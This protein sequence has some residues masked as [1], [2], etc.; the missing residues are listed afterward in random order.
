MKKF[1]KILYRIWKSLISILGYLVAL[2][3]IAVLCIVF[4]WYPIKVSSY[5][6][7]NPTH[8]NHKTSYLEDISSQHISDSLKPNVVI[9]MFDDLGHGDLSSYGNKLIQTPNIDSVARKGIKFTNF[10]SSSP[11][12]TP[13]RAG[14]LT[15]RL[16]IRTLAGNVYFQTGS[17][18]AN[19]QK[20]MGNKNELP[21]DEILLPEVFKA[22]GYTTGMMGK[23]HL[24][25]TNGHLPN[26]FGFDHFYG[27]HYSNDMLPLHVYRNEDIEI[28]DKTEMADGSKLHTDHQDDIKTPGL[29]Q[30][31]L[32]HLYT[33]NATKFITDNKDNPFLLYFAHSFPHVPHYA[34]KDHAG[35]SD[36]GLYGD[37]VEDLDRSVKVVMD[38]LQKNGL[39][40]NTIVIITSDNG[41]DLNGSAG[42]LKGKKQT[43]FEGGQRVPLIVQWK[44]HLPAGLETDQMAMNTD[45]FPTLLNVLNI[46]VPKDRMIDGKNIWPILQGKK[47]PH[48]YLY[49]T[50]NSNGEIKGIRND[51]YKYH[52]A[53]YQAMPLFGTI[54]FVK[55]QKPQLNDLLLDGETHN[56]IEKYPDIS[57]DLELQ[58][59]K[60]IEELDLKNNKRGWLN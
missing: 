2:L 21:Q 24:G 36:G 32:T 43:T 54:G 56:L 47:S 14:M 22:A 5:E 16:P 13:S 12:C 30:S 46:P 19:V 57:K 33:E 52:V 6:P 59:N 27:V 42:N 29:D 41:A 23:W 39:E 28:E 48:D 55:N 53:A 4:I 20:V 45:F 34:S 7:E 51:R 38:A 1:F 50:K 18:F 31:K 40:E 17:T 44:N 35:E 15:G 10:Y 37:I 11:V 58:M 60:K 26:D 49:Y 8:L 25:D 3:I 9:I